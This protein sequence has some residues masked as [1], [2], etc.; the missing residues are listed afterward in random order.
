MPIE[1]NNYICVPPPLIPAGSGITPAKEA[2]SAKEE[3]CVPFKD[4]PDTYFNVKRAQAR[5]MDKILKKRDTDN[6]K[7]DFDMMVE[8]YTI[9]WLIGRELGND[10][11][12]QDGQEKLFTDYY[13]IGRDVASLVAYLQDP[14]HYSLVERKQMV[15][16]VRFWQAKITLILIGDIENPDSRR[17]LHLLFQGAPSL[18]VKF[19]DKDAYGNAEKLEML[20]EFYQHLPKLYDDLLEKPRHPKDKDKRGDPLL[21]AEC[22]LAQYELRASDPTAKLEPS[23][24]LGYLKTLLTRVTAEMKN[25]GDKVYYIHN[26]IPDQGNIP[27][28]LRAKGGST[29][30][31]K[32]DAIRRRE[33]NRYL[34]QAQVLQARLTVLETG[35]RSPDFVG[36]MKT[37]LRH[38]SEAQQ[39]I[40]KYG[41]DPKQIQIALDDLGAPENFS[42]GKYGKTYG[43]LLNA[44]FIEYQKA[45]INY[46]LGLYYQNQGPSHNLESKTRFNAAQALTENVAGVLQAIAD[47]YGR[48]KKNPM[49]NSYLLRA[50]LLG[51]A[52]RLRA[53]ILLAR[54]ENQKV[55]LDLAL[56]L[57]KETLASVKLTDLKQRLVIDESESVARLRL[58]RADAL[59]R[60][61]SKDQAVETAKINE[62]EGILKPLSD[63]LKKTPAEQP[64]YAVRL[65]GSIKLMQAK[66]ELAKYHLTELDEQHAREAIKLLSEIIPK[67]ESDGQYRPTPS[68]WP[69]GRLPYHGL[70]EDYELSFALQTRAEAKSSLGD[71][72][73]AKV[74]FKGALEVYK[75]ADGKSLNYFALVGQADLANWSGNYEEAAT[76]Y[77]Q[78]LKGY[79]LPDGVKDRIALGQAE[80]VLRQKTLSP[81]AIADAE[82]D[83][84]IEVARRIMMTSD[85]LPLIER[86]LQSLVEALVA[87]KRAGK[88][89]L[90]MLR[91]KLFAQNFDLAGYLRQPFRKFETLPAQ[92]DIALKGAQPRDYARASFQLALADGFQFIYQYQAGKDLLAGFT[93]KYKG[94]FDDTKKN[95]IHPHYLLAAAE[96][97]LRL[98]QNNKLAAEKIAGNIRTA[99]KE[100]F[101]LKGDR[102]DPYL[103]ARALNDLI[104]ICVNNDQFDQALAFTYLALGKQPPE[105]KKEFEAL[106]LDGVIKPEVTGLTLDQ[107][108]DEA[109]KLWPGNFNVNEVFHNKGLDKKWQLFSRDLRI[110]Q[111]EIM[112][113]TKNFEQAGK[114]FGQVAADIDKAPAEEKKLFRESLTLQKARILVGLGNI[115]S[116]S[117]VHQ[118]FGAALK[119]YDAALKLISELKAADH[120]QELILVM[121]ELYV[122]LANVRRYGRGVDDQKKRI[123][124][125]DESA[126]YYQKAAD[127][128]EKIKGN[129]DLKYY[130][131]ARIYF[132]LAKIAEERGHLYLQ[133]AGEAVE[134]RP[135]DLLAKA[136]A[137]WAK[138][139]RQDKYANQ[140]LDGELKINYQNLARGWQAPN[141]QLTTRSIHAPRGLIKQAAEEMRLAL[142][143]TESFTNLWGSKL[144]VDM[145]GKINL[146]SDLQ[147]GSTIETAFLGVRAKPLYWLSVEGDYKLGS[148][149]Q[150]KPDFL[151]QYLST[152]TLMLS[153]DMSAPGDIPFI[154]GLSSTVATDLYLSSKDKG[155]N[156]RDS[157]YANLFY[158]FGRHSNPFVQAGSL[159]LQAYSFG[160]FYNGD[161]L[162]RFRLAPTATYELDLKELDFKD[163]D[164]WFNK[165]V[166]HNGMVRL[167]VEASLIGEWAF[168]PMRFN[169]AMTTVRQDNLGFS[170]GAH[171]Q[172]NCRP[173]PILGQVK[174][175][176]FINY[177]Y[178]YQDLQNY[179]H[180]DNREQTKLEFGLGLSHTF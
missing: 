91:D 83:K 10:Y 142:K 114:L 41:D 108:A 22:L 63:K 157:R 81:E 98:N 2:A 171:M 161:L 113:W 128:A 153:L 165:L 86:A 99:A 109:G 155:A 160:F 44:L 110:K 96:L 12:L 28:Y 69:A 100:I 146:D 77:D 30:Y 57:L 104:D 32:G 78:A 117:R 137:F 150:I 1:L 50:T 58:S 16:R 107:A 5:L 80:A 54:N 118:N 88:D 174:A 112:A 3:G 148:S 164:S 144:E 132:G 101:A 4:D 176:L 173:W 121:T 122:N 102:R 141:F 156:Y 84:V 70:L 103:T 140:Q 45:E 169:N 138:I 67:P 9:R 92:K 52:K 97:D 89:G 139:V 61:R 21:E 35:Y 66:L 73:G 75:N 24:D 27:K 47:V 20:R 34:A 31:W 14:G 94:Y 8:A 163:K 172:F 76:L 6:D 175:N 123:K 126:V 177:E 151:M 136:E 125:L 79:N 158:N 115:A 166:K 167:G 168:N 42:L 106:K 29:K 119:Y 178:I 105:I 71:F 64:P 56:P 145:I 38:L 111:A 134:Y 55:N 143:L 127:L 65:A 23:K 46:R 51:Q 159:G 116:Q 60:Q 93:E 18:A 120:G 133:E 129:D 25:Q 131:L 154:R 147:S 179:Y 37:A 124:E 74:D 85:E 82:A 90:E 33:A 26:R 11:I 152:P 72:S 135:S 39:L 36:N 13:K 19:A 49:E 149:A 59:L 15:M 17:V 40:D 180:L 48:F 68:T 62:A 170:A 43:D 162:K 130:H 7:P 95:L 87:Q 53:D